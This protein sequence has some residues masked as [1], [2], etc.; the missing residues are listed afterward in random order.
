MAHWIP[1]YGPV[2]NRL[3]GDP[4]RA[5]ARKD[6]LRGS[7]WEAVRRISGLI[8]LLRGRKNGRRNQPNN[9]ASQ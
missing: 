8:V 5:G 7:G 1:R 3:P 4:S 2:S 9:P 6:G